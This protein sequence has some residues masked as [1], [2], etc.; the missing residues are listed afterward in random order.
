MEQSSDRPSTILVDPS[1]GAPEANTRPLVPTLLFLS[2]A[3]ALLVV[4][5]L[6]RLDACPWRPLC[7]PITADDISQ[8]RLDTALPAPQSD[9]IIEQT[10]APQ[11]NG[12]NEVELI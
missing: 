8:G 4:V 6:G 7:G 12:L 11:H 3:V 10:F 1:P 5:A 9:L 2:A